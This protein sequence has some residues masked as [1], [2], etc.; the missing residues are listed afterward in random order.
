MEVAMRYSMMSYTMARGEWGKT[1][2]VAELCRITADMGLEGID[3]V[4]TYGADAREVRMVMDD[5]GLR[6]VCYTFFADINYPEAGARQDGIDAIKRGI[7]TALVLGTDKVMIPFPGKDGVTRLQSRSNVIEGLRR[8]M[9][10]AKSCGVA[11][12]TEHFSMHNAPFIVSQ[13][14]NDAIRELPDLKVTF[15]SGNVQIGGESPSDAF[16]RSRDAIIHCHFKDF[17]RIQ[18]APGRYR[19]LDGDSY[20]AALIGEGIIDYPALVST[21]TTAEYDGWIN[22]EYEGDKYPADEAVRRALA[23]LSSVEAKLAAPHHKA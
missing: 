22:L 3:W 15:D 18:D 5:T 8:V 4:T 6:T 17:E 9:D 19:G 10:Y 1:H 20:Y 2:N 12:S 7:D 21:M 16:L 23:Y 11:L 13:D 14:V